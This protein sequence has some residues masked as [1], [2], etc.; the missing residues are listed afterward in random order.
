MG[1]LDHERVTD[2]GRGGDDPAIDCVQKTRPPRGLARVFEQRS[3]RRR[4]YDNSSDVAAVA[5][6]RDRGARPGEG[7][8][9]DELSLREGEAY[10]RVGPRKGGEAADVSRDECGLQIHPAREL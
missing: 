5:V 3:S 2:I 6:D 7:R 1:K 10:A 8:T 9:P 4:R